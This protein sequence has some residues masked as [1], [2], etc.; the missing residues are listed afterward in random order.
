[1]LCYHLFFLV[2][3]TIWVSPT[4]RVC[5]LVTFMTRAS[6][7]SGVGGIRAGLREIRGCKKSSKQTDKQIRPGRAGGKKGTQT[8]FFC[9][10]TA[11]WSELRGKTKDGSVAKQMYLSIYTNTHFAFQTNSIGNLD[12]YAN[13]IFLPDHCFPACRALC[14]RSR[15]NP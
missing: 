4:F 1:M 2:T 12:K 14:H 8:G 3:S 5:S 7:G 11:H 13:M 6:K 10:I 9:R 15:L